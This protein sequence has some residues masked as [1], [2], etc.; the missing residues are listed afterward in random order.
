VVVAAPPAAVA[1]SPARALP[2]SSSPR[3][4]GAQWAKASAPR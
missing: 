3:R 4:S 2:S 1:A